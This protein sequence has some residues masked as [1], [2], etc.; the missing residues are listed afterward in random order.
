MKKHHRKGYHFFP[1]MEGGH[2]I[3]PAV[4]V[5]TSLNSFSYVTN[6]RA[7]S[8]GEVKNTEPHKAAASRLADFDV[9][10]GMISFAHRPS[11]RGAN[12]NDLAILR[13]SD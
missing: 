3:H 11:S 5:P 7:S 12:N 10:A 6:D 1:N 9:M 2:P 13:P 8:S 4:S